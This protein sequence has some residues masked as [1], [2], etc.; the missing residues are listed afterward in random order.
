MARIMRPDWEDA[1]HHIMARGID[2]RTLFSNLSEYEDLRSRL[3]Q[4]VVE[5]KFSVYAWVIMPNHLHL[6]IR[7]G[8]EP[9]SLLMHRLLTGF[10]ISYNRR[11]DR[12]GHVFQGRFKSI[13][14]QEENYFL[15]LINY[16]HLNPLKAKVVNSLE[17]LDTYKWSGHPC[18]IGKMEC[19]WMK[20]D[21]VL[22]YFGD[23]EYYAIKN[24]QTSLLN[25]VNSMASSEM[26]SG[27]FSI[28]KNG[29]KSSD[30]RT[31]TSHWTGICRVLGDK[32]FAKRVLSR[33]NDFKSLEVRNRENIHKRIERLFDQ[34]VVKMGL[35]R[36]VIRG[37][38]RSSELAE[39]RGAIAWICSQKFG[40]SYRD[41]SRLLNVSRSG[42]AKAVR[43][44]A[45]LQREHPFIIEILIS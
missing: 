8:P 23:T 40:L 33:L 26:V 19:K 45:E 44:G 43:R 1:L 12:S 28:G 29:I 35:S 24:Y 32:E 5:L 21:S 3:E 13:L 4:L 15:K 11:H 36:E 25:D 34:I 7:T 18:L 42:A 30:Q 14:V 2:G 41:I 16:V 37:N 17:E 27:N 6:L 39:A 10:A 31:G 38:S 20:R 9:I 22:E